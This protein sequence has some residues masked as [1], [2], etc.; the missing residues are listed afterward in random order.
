MSDTRLIN[1]R[2]TYRHLQV[3][4]RF[5]V[6][7]DLAFAGATA[8]L[9]LPLPSGYWITSGQ[10]FATSG[11]PAQSWP[12]RVRKSSNLENV[13]DRFPLSARAGSE[14]SRRWS[15]APNLIRRLSRISFV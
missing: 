1:V 2:G 4:F 8:G 9:C 5:L 12:R 7:T 11:L 10:R 3:F 15:N 13:S 14:I 6:S